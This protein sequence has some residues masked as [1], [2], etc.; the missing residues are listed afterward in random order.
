MAPQSHRRPPAYFKWPSVTVIRQSRLRMC[1]A[2]LHVI[3]SVSSCAVLNGPLFTW[4]IKTKYLLY[5]LLYVCKIVSIKF[6]NYPWQHL[7]SIFVAPDN[8][9]MDDIVQHETIRAHTDC[10]F[11]HFDVYQQF[12]CDKNVS[13]LCLEGRWKPWEDEIGIKLYG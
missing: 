10:I 3:F 8:L 1:C 11:L 12:W 13:V 5:P 9:L 2:L 7:P 4:S 6:R